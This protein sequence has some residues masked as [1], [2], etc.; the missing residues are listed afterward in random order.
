MTVTMALYSNMCLSYNSD[1]IQCLVSHSELCSMLVFISVILLLRVHLV[2]LRSCV[3]SRCLFWR[4]KLLIYIVACD[5]VS[6]I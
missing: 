1:V 3:L 2:L 4:I 6:R 5:T